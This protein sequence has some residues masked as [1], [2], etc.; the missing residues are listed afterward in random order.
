MNS[1]SPNLHRAVERAR[2][3]AELAAALDSADK[4]ART[5]CERPDSSREATVLRHHISELQDEVDML[6][7]GRR[8]PPGG[9]DPDWI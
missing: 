3:L 2:W 6:R 4:L 1:V 5:L 9:F 8:E 7:R